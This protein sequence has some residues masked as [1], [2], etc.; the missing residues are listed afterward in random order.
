[1]ID[2]LAIFQKAM[3]SNILMIHTLFVNDDATHIYIVYEG[4]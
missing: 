4:E 2:I 1:M 3:Y